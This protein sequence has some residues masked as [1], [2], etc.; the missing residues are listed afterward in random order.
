[1]VKMVMKGCVINMFAIGDYIAYGLT[2]VCKVTEIKEERFLN[3]PTQSF[4]IL[5]PVFSPEMTIKVPVLA[6]NSPFRNIYSKDEIEQLIFKIPK[7]ELLWINDER[8]R[9]QRFK[10]MLRKCEVD[11]WMTLI[12]TIY[13]YKYLPEFKGKKLNKNDEEILKTAEKLLN[14]EF[15]FVLNLNPEEI[16][17]YIEHCIA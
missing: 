14:Q 16:P 3:Y 5:N 10:D 15:G 12:K 17:S 8:E 1:M 6:Q 13:S 11:D 9:N 7:W 4:Y 2:G